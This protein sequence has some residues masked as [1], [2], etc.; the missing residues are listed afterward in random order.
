MLD[1]G[2]IADAAHIN[3]LR[4]LARDFEAH[5]LHR[6]GRRT[7]PA[8]GAQPGRRRRVPRRGRRAAAWTR[9]VA[10]YAPALILRKRSQQGLVEIFQTIVR[11]LQETGDSPSGILPLVDPDHRPESIADPIPG[12]VVAVDDELFLPLP[13]N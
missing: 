8:P 6:D 1:P 7:G 3:D 10:S 2:L 13:V 12:A 4:M 11:Q 5:P 9:A